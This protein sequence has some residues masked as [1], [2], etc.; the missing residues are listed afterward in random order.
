MVKYRIGGHVVGPAEAK[1][2]SRYRRNVVILSPTPGSCSGPILTIPPR[3]EIR[4]RL[5]EAFKVGT[6][7]LELLENRTKHLLGGS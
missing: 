2:S 4:W 3:I 6:D 5:G 7:P 1:P